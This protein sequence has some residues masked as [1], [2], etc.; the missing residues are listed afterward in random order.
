M[1]NLTYLLKCF[2]MHKWTKSS[3]NSY[4]AYH[5]PWIENLVFIDDILSIYRTAPKGYWTSIIESEEYQ[6]NR[7]NID[8]F[9]TDKSM[10]KSSVKRAEQCM[11]FVKILKIYR[12]HIRYIGKYIRY[13]GDIFGKY[14]RFFWN[15]KKIYIFILFLFFNLF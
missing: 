7:Q 6:K 12:R 5:E 11:K 10:K 3:Y 4:K 13:I 2:Y 14:W 1:C 15:L 9:G 8:L